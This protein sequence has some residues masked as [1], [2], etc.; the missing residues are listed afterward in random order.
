MQ[1]EVGKERRI[2]DK[3]RK[4]PGVIEAMP[5]LGEYDVVVRIELNDFSVLEQAVTMI[6]RIPGVLRTTTLIS[7]S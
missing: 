7:R 2:V 1:T 5:V 3:A 4:F 6:R